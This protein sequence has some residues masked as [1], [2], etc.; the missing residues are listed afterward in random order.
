MRFSRVAIALVIAL[1]LA[2]EA[3]AGG[4]AASAPAAAVVSASPAVATAASTPLAVALSTSTPQAST[5]APASATPLATVRATATPSAEAAPGA[6]LW[7]NIQMVI[8]A[9]ELA[10]SST[11]LSP[12]R[13][14]T[15]SS[16]RIPAAGE[17][18]TVVTEAASVSPHEVDEAGCV[19]T[20][21]FTKPNLEM[22]VY[23]SGDSSILAGV[24]GPDWYY[25]VQCP[26]DPRPPPPFRMPAF[27]SEGLRYFL[28]YALAPYRVTEGLRLPTSPHTGGPGCVQRSATISGSAFNADVEV[29]V[30]VY[31][32]DVPGGCLLP[33]P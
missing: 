20:R 33:V 18:P 5:I 25:Q 8:T 10:V 15:S 32:A 14:E 11:G 19:W 2:A 13:I 27:G 31:Q 28:Q 12:I 9:K 22:T 30:F 6:E 26:G 4:G 29:H 3:C 16:Q 17:A 1:S 21:T 24:D 23:D 7:V